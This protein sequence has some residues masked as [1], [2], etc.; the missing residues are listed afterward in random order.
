MLRNEKSKTKYHGQFYQVDAKVFDLGLKPIPFAVYSYLVFCAGHKRNCFPSV[1]TIAKMC[2]CSESAVRSAI[3]ELTALGL[4]SKEYC[5]RE[6]RYGVRQQTSNTYG[7]L[8]IPRYYENG[9]PRYD[10]DDEL[11][12]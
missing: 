8:P 5:Y 10:Y 2:S 7:I 3:K 12:F 4:I 11:P 9:A 1:R 6:N